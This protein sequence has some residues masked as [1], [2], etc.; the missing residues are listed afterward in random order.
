MALNRHYATLQF[1]A[2]TETDSEVFQYCYAMLM[3][4]LAQINVR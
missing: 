1:T 2:L 4:Y 3:G